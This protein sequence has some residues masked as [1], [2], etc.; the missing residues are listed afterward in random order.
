MQVYISGLIYKFSKEE[1]LLN[2]LYI[3]GGKVTQSLLWVANNVAFTS[4]G[5][6]FQILSST[7]SLMILREL[8]FAPFILLFLGIVYFKFRTKILRTFGKRPSK[9]E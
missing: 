4:N 7:M 3:K 5:L 9:T 2:R 1:H 6:Y 8:M